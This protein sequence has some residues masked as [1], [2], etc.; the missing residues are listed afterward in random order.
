MIGSRMKASPLAHAASRM[1]LSPVRQRVAAG[2][3][4]LELE[5]PGSLLSIASEPAP[6]GER[7]HER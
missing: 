2:C 3:A 6:E 1:I 7:C 4:P 5:T